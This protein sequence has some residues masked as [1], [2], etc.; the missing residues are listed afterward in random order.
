MLITFLSLQ[1]KT[2]STKTGAASFSN[3]LSMARGY[4]MALL[5]A[6][7]V[8]YLIHSSSAETTYTVGD[9]TGWIVPQNGAAFYSTWAANKTFKVGDILGNTTTHA[10][11]FISTI[12]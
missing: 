7:S 2:E 11:I 12:F 9:T 1:G 5:A 3:T 6:I 8:A 10:V 4:G